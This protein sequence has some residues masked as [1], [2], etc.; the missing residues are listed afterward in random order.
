MD[1]KPCCTRPLW[2]W[3]ACMQ[4]SVVDMGWI[5][6]W[7]IWSIYDNSWVAKHFTLQYF[8]HFCAHAHSC[9]NPVS[10]IASIKDMPLCTWRFDHCFWFFWVN[11]ICFNHGCMNQVGQNPQ[12]K[13]LW[14][15]LCISI[16]TICL[17]DRRSIEAPSNHSM[18]SQGSPVFIQRSPAAGS[19]GLFWGRAETQLSFRGSTHGKG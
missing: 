15:N 3:P 1:D 8:L 9:L 12:L 13:Y 11:V 19:F 18:Y 14:Y 7:W 10:S 2:T 16:Y 4:T 5:L 6:L 17:A